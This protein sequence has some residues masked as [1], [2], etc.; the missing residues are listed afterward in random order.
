[1]GTRFFLVAG[2]FKKQDAWWIDYYYQGKRHR[3]KIGA[4]RKAEDAITQIIAAGDFIPPE[5]RRQE[6]ALAHSAGSY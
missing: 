6:D 3:Q 1:V 5:Q 4:K 2:V